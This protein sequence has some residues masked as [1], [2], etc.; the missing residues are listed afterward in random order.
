MS[1]NKSKASYL[2]LARHHLVCLVV[3]AVSAGSPFPNRLPRWTG[4]RRR[5]G[6]SI[7]PWNPDQPERFQEA[8]DA[9]KGPGDGGDVSLNFVE[10]RD[11]SGGWRRGRLGRKEAL[12]SLRYHLTDG[13]VVVLGVLAQGGLELFTPQQIARAF[14]ELWISQLGMA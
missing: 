12:Q 1:T 2:V 7:W 9:L 8:T 4:Q 3:S 11:G 10:V 5:Q 13:L 6:R 14:C